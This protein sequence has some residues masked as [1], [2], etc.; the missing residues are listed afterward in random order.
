MDNITHTLVGLAAGELIHRSLPEEPTLE[1]QGT[2]RRLLL[3]SCFLASNFPDLDLFLT[4]LLPAPL[5]Y[6]LHHR[7][8]THTL[9]YEIPQAILLVALIWFLSKPARLLLKGSSLARLGLAASVGAGFVLHILLDSFN[10]YGIHPFHPFNSDWYYGDSIFIIEPVFWISFGLPLAMMMRKA[11]TKWFA[12]SFLTVMP[13]LFA[14]KKY[15][16]PVALILLLAI[17]A[18]LV[19]WQSKAGLRSRR[20]LLTAFVI[21]IGFIGVQKTAS[22]MAKSRVRFGAEK[23]DSSFEM[24]DVA[25]TPAPTNPLCWGFIAI[26]KHKTSEV[27]KLTRGRLSLAPEVFPVDSCAEVVSEAPNL[28]VN[29]GHKEVLPGL[30]FLTE[31]RG[32][33]A[34]LR[35]L[36]K[37]NCHVNA[38]MRFARAPIVT[39][40]EANDLRFTMR[41]SRANFTLMNIPAMAVHACSD[42]IPQWSRPREDLL[43]PI[44]RHDNEM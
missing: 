22:N 34:L 35:T 25:A 24:L 3:V 26:E 27:Y 12:L 43:S 36:V 14:Y 29:D 8:H 13:L 9:F 16:H 28:A 30:V 15:L 20:V 42:A 19:F 7:G 4:P 40:T 37:E 41:G 17:G 31:E 10:S 21:S 23:I 11:W 38:W 2:R 1:S 39:E 5:G 33:L 44:L 32:D 6:L 18:G